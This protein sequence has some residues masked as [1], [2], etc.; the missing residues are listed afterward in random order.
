MTRRLRIWSFVGIAALLPAAWA[1]AQ[2]GGSGSIQ[3]TVLDGSG[4]A[5]PGATVT[6]THAGTGIDTTRQATT[7]GV[8]TLSPLA[9]GE[10]R[11]TVTLQGFQTFVQE[12]VIVDA[13]GVVGL[14]VTLKVGGI[15][16]EVT[17]S[18]TPP[19]LRT[20]DG[21]LG[22]T[23]RNDVYTAL[24]L[25]MNT[26]GPRD[27][28][29]FMFL[30]P[31]VQSVGRWGNVMG[32]QDFTNDTYVEGVPI[33]NSVVQGEGRN[34]SFGISVEAIDQFQ[35]ETSGTAV[36]YNGQGASNYVVK[37]GTNQIRGSAFEFF[38]NK[39]LDSKAFFAAAKPD[40]NQHEFGFT[41][42]GPLRRNQAFFFVAYDRY[43]DRR[44]TESRLISIPTAAQRNGDFSGLPVVIYDPATTRP[45]P[46]GTGFVR[47]PF[48]GNIIPASRIS[49]ISRNL[50]S[51]L[52][53]PSNANLQNNYLGGQLPIG[54]NND[55]VTTKVDLRLSSRHQVAVLFAHGKRSQATPYRGGTNA[56]TQL[57][58]PY[59]ETRLV[60][61]IPTTAQ[62]K[63][64]YVIG[65]RWVNQASLG[66][67]RLSVPIAN[68]T[69]DG[70][71]A[72]GAG[73]TGL[74]AGEADGAFPEVSYAGPNAPTNWRGTDARAFTEYLNNFTLQ[75][76]LQWTRGKH[77]ITF[78]FQAQRMDANERERTYGSLATFA[79]SNS[80]TAGFT[81]TGTLNAAT[82]NAYASFLLGDLNAA[83]VIEDSQVATSGRFRTYA[84]WAQ[85]DFKVTSRLA[86]NLGLRYDIMRPYTEV[87][88]R[89]SFMNP[90][91]PNTAVG[92]FPGAM[93]FAGFGDNSCQ[94]RTPIKTY[95]G[96]IGP[97]VGAAYSLN[98]RTVLRGSSGIMYSRRG[99]VGGRAGARN[100]TGTLGLSA[101]ASFP[102]SNGFAPAFN[103]NTGVPAYPKP[104]FLDPTLN[105][106][107]VTGR[108]SGGGVT[109]GDPEIGGRPPRYQNWN[110]GAQY[111]LTSTITVGAAYAGSHGDF[112]GG[113]GRGF[114]SNQL[115]P[116]YLALGNL[117]TQN[118]TA[119]NIAAARAIVPDV[120][121]PYA[122]FSGTIAQMLRPFPQYS[123][124]TDVYGNVARSNYHSLQLTVEQR[125]VR[126]LTLNA[127]YT[128]SRT[129]DDLAART[130]YDFAQDWAVG[131]NDQPHVANVIAV[132]DVPFG[133]E[134][135][136]GS[137]N[138]FVRSLVRG[139]QVSGITQFRS[140]RPLGAI[141]GACNLPS[142]G[143]CYADFNPDFSGPVRINGD[144]G[145]GDVLGTTPPTYIDRNAFQ[146]APAFAYGNTP[147]TLAFG[148]RNPNS[149]N[150]DLSVQRDFA[151]R[152]TLKVRL[153]L[154]VFNLFN[155]VIFGGINANIT[156]ANFGRVSSQTNQPRVAQ[157]KVRVTF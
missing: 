19:M 57:P 80:Q 31:G 61:E 153:G 79:F 115:D 152:P 118:A 90:D 11:V 42:G 33:T 66:F 14:N 40:D 15:T 74:P 50:Q 88:D 28:T 120:A 130:G 95:F 122:S 37:S 108:P 141:I 82:G 77:A 125:R 102:S 119:A 105:A 47:D 87:Y 56:Q 114:Y 145:D 9:P 59:T 16:Q 91:L 99:A 1:D 106:G 96:N 150:Q 62:V 124:V 26:G 58:L 138:A 64:T 13:L 30:M 136:P 147:R 22:Q 142:A 116:R 85:D 135:Q 78:G 45:N 55:N 49:P 70:A 76:N 103:W 157:I 60:E 53:D 2:I 24:P 137:G 41:V 44:Q 36:M 6:A 10:Y 112:L 46:N 146:S 84:F 25:V 151:L 8:Y 51:Y 144:Y 71:F 68:A 98:D 104:P 126:G 18:A 154:E 75:D 133:A 73:I 17:V 148:L 81:A 21:R 134:G 132:Y 23:I 131:L 109:Y 48:P 94:C 113:S 20:A 34:L 111:A 29:A 101:N 69:I 72:R 83:N 123:G 27:P 38:R 156:N 63:H 117:L 65:S 107:F 100:G 110:V 39:G 7:A 128:F 143:T 140:G 32:G 97:R 89:W 43:R 129:E 5:L 35:V 86:L 155:T 121:L 92:G 52:P 3:G 4:A 54:F 139:W 12:A 93:Q 149:V 127:N 67:A